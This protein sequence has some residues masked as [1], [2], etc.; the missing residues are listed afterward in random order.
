MAVKDS[1]LLITSDGAIQSTPTGGNARGSKAVDL[2]VTR[3]GIA[4]VASGANSGILAGE[5]NTAN[6]T[7]SFVG[8]GN[9]NSASALHAAS[10]AGFGNIASGANSFVGAGN[11]NTASA[12]NSTVSGGAS[13]TAS[14]SGGSVVAGG[15]NNISSGAD[16]FVGGGNGNTASAQESAV[17]SG[18]S[19]VASTR[20]ATVL[21]GISAKAYLWGQKSHNAGIFAAAADSQ[22]SELLWRIA[23]TDATANVESFL[24]GGTARAV[25]PLN[26]TWAFEIYTIARSSAGVCAMWKT[27]GAIQNNANTVSLV[28]A[29]TQSVIADGTGT[30][31]G[32]T[33]NHVVSADN[34]NKSL[35]VAVTGAVA[36]NI[37][38]VTRARLV[39]VGF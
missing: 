39:E 15:D 10:V 31:W 22:T 35:K 30:T 14:G 29:V 13:N 24:D 3:T 25:I 38:W 16:S 5:S 27:E 28:A 37:R 17:L 33:A 19:N 2:Q 9:S 23:T 1:K 34:T 26:T 21:G 8:G 20:I 36:T 32:V 18:N 6:G 11:G 7:D 12:P 4:Q